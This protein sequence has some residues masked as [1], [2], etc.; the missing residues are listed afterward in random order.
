MPMFYLMP[1]RRA[2]SQSTALASKLQ[3]CTLILCILFLLAAC[4]A[5][6]KTTAMAIGN[7]QPSLPHAHL[8][9]D[10][11]TLLAHAEAVH[12]A[13]RESE[14]IWQN[15]WLP[16]Q[17]FILY[18]RQGPALLYSHS[19]P[20]A[21]GLMVAPNTYFYP[22]GLDQLTDSI[23]LR[24]PV[25][26]TTVTAVTL[27][28]SVEETTGLL[29]HE[30]FHVHQA[31]YFN[32]RLEARFVDDALFTDAEVRALLEMR[33]QVLLK[34][35]Q[36]RAP[37]AQTSLAQHLQALLTLDDELRKRI[38]DAALERLYQL[39]IIEGTAELVGLRAHLLSLPDYPRAVDLQASL[40]SNLSQRL[41]RPEAGIH[42][43]SD[44]RLYAYGSGAASVFLL[45]QLSSDYQ[46]LISSGLVDAQVLTLL[47]PRAS[48]RSLTEIYADYDYAGWL[49][50]AEADEASRQQLSLPDFAAL[51]PATL[52]IAIGLHSAA[53]AQALNVN[54]SSGVQGF[55]QPTEGSYMLPQPQSVSVHGRH[56]SLLIEG[57]AT[58]LISPQQDN[59]TLRLQIK[60]DSLPTLCAHNPD[61][62]RV[63]SCE[64]DTIN[65][66]WQ[67]VQFE[68]QA[69]TIVN[70]R[71]Q[72]LHIDVHEH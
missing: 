18:Q 53:A 23:F 9:A 56:T 6:P 1:S 71:G 65:F 8:P 27:Q 32:Q 51:T 31:E 19:E 5:Q 72:H 49:S 67:G 69:T 52:D 61:G 29:F 14:L 50:W 45:A 42:S 60:V 64:L 33:R 57:P 11:R 48:S 40:I 41:Q 70:Q 46:A 24:Y 63:L 3:R 25:G 47:A 58:H 30:A 21:G 37:D 10:A 43:A 7:D 26:D 34:A 66:H 4:H 20:L 54:F 17:G 28:S 22:T 44:L 62:T 35:L 38:G 12:R 59:P 15:F 36:E 39:E 16:Q 68:H 2:L 13:S 55:S